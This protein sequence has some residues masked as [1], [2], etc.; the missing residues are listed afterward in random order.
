MTQCFWIL[1]VFLIL[2]SGGNNF[3]SW[4]TANLQEPDATNSSAMNACVLN[5]SFCNA[6][7]SMFL[8]K[9]SLAGSSFDLFSEVYGYGRG[10]ARY[11][12]QYAGRRPYGLHALSPSLLHN[13]TALCFAVGERAFTVRIYISQESCVFQKRC[14]N[15]TR[16][17]LN[18]TS[19]WSWAPDAKRCIPRG[20]LTVWFLRSSVP[21]AKWTLCFPSGR[22][23]SMGGK[24]SGTDIGLTWLTCIVAKRAIEFVWQDLSFTPK[25]ATPKSHW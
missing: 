13:V 10:H 3:P 2:Q 15:T 21:F 25:N 11:D 18:K 9:P 17:Q 20:I 19:S 8:F 24:S 23:L 1:C 22:I 12:H 4:R 7:V 5:F 6:P 14:G 16:T